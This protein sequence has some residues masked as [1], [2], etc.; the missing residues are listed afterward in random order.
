M[1]HQ[2]TLQP[3]ITS[4]KS[5]KEK[6]PIEFPKSVVDKL[7]Q[8]KET[9][10]SEQKPRRIAAVTF[11]FRQIF[12]TLEL[13][14]CYEKA[15]FPS[16]IEF[17]GAIFLE[18]RFSE[19]RYKQFQET[20]MNDNVKVQQAINYFTMNYLFATEEFDRLQ[21]DETISKLTVECT[22]YLAS[23]MKNMWELILQNEFPKRNFVVS[24]ELADNVWGVTFYEEQRATR[25]PVKR[26]LGDVLDLPDFPPIPLRSLQ[27]AY[28]KRYEEHPR[29][30]PINN[31]RA[32]LK[33]IE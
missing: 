21:Q 17:E 23:R 31:L 20:F 8:F 28:K 15:F 24:I 27:K 22:K 4:E 14:L 26:L 18:E 12:G 11:P 5:Q 13:A 6:I 16:F 2:S 3:K 7:P 33:N 25:A 29:A 1:E 9:D 19:K 10:I 32:A 30:H